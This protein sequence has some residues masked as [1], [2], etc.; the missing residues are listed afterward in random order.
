MR[1]RKSAISEAREQKCMACFVMVRPQIW[2][3]I[4]SNEQIVTC[5]SCVRIL[6]F[7]PANEVV[8]EPLKKKS[9]PR[10]VEEEAVVHAEASESETAATPEASPAK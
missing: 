2:Q 1:Q 6:Y 8:Q 10:N 3:E 7:D 9:K 4:R 5:S